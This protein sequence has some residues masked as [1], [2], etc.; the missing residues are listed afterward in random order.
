MSK[1]LLGAP[2]AK[3]ICERLNPVVEELKAKGVCPALA[4]VRVGQ[5]EDDIA[6]EQAAIKRMASLGI[7]TKQF[8]FPDDVNDK[9]LIS[10]I[11]E[12]N[13][14]DNI[15]GCL[16]FRPLKDKD[17]EE[18]VIKTLN[19]K[20]D[21]DC[22]T[23]IALS[24]VFAGKG[25]GYPPCTAKACVELLKYYG[26]ELTGKNITVVG[27]SLVIGKPVAMMLL[28]ENATVTMAHTRTKNLE[29]VCNKAD[30]LVVAAGKAKVVSKQH[31]NPN[32]IVVDVGINVDGDSIVG[33]VDF[34]EVESV[35]EAITPVPRGVGSIT[36]A[37]LASHV[38]AAAGK[39][40]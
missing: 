31:V 29:E 6:Y 19:P 18:E 38:V 1:L 34:E 39:T 22:M 14:D 36:T 8:L 30:I 37:V 26:Y 40:I 25:E 32:Q 12:I 20:K 7:E 11:E 17:L 15:H 33:D 24:S 9:E 13:K 35:V 27:R 5:K 21:M 16:F 4:L 3:E 10:C 2:V 23:A 28:A